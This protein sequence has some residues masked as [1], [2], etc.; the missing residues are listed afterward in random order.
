MSLANATRGVHRL[1]T[2][3]HRQNV[4]PSA[5]R[6]K[7]P[8]LVRNFGHEQVQSSTEL[9]H[10]FL[11]IQRTHGDF[12]RL[13]INDKLLY[14]ATHPRHVRHVLIDAS[15][16][17]RKTRT[18]AQAGLVI[19]NSLLASEGEFAINQ[20]R[21]L[22]PVHGPPQLARLIRVTI[23]LTDAMLKR[24]QSTADRQQPVNVM[25]E[26]SKLSLR[27]FAEL[28][29]GSTDL[30]DGHPLGPA[31]ATV[32]KT[33]RLF[34]RTPFS[35]VDLVSER[36]SEA[37]TASLATVDQAVGT[38]IA[39]RAAGEPADD[40][41]SLMVHLRDVENGSMS[42]RQVRDEAMTLLFAGYSTTALALT[43]TWLC[44]SD[45]PAVEAQ[46]HTELLEQ[47]SQLTAALK[48]MHQL[49]V[50]TRVVREA[51]RL[52]PP[53]W[54]IARVAVEDDE[55]DGYEVPGDSVIVLSPSVTQ[56][57][58]EFWTSPDAYDPCRFGSEPRAVRHDYAYFPFSLGPHRCFGETMAILLM[59]LV[60]GR[61]G[62]R[63]RVRRTAGNSVVLERL[64]T[65]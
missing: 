26:M 36:G 37:F 54:M 17:Y 61:V 22:Q 60:I 19:G 44:L 32:F 53:S 39:R 27:I 2:G 16:S 28:I 24:W 12:S 51:L 31:L 64:E 35:R 59:Q 33:L 18:Y 29:F 11:D 21:L 56:R 5:R 15:A 62:Q 6:R 65:R 45:N 1:P 14:L 20:R 34:L 50:T 46:L 43:Q 40:L 7:P 55:I 52:H 10:L 58:H 23:A 13:Y 42:A 63:F 49:V 38:L 3:D 48:D 8:T 41:L 25:S 30:V 47:F 9:V 4:M 57:H